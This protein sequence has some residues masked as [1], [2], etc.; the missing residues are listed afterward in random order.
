M[1]C[2]IRRLALDEEIVAEPAGAAAAAAF[3]KTNPDQAAGS[4][5][6]L[7]TGRNVTRDVL[8]AAM[9]S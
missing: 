6:V 5:A 4:V 2:A 3:L 1:L 9:S 7:V 8:Q